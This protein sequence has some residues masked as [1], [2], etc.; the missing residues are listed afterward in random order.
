MMPVSTPKKIDDSIK[1]FCNS[2]Q[3][4]HSPTFVDFFEV[5][6]CKE[7]ECFYNVQEMVKHNGGEIIYG[8]TVWSWPNVYM[9]AEHHAVWRNPGGQL[10]DVTPKVH[11]EKI[12]LFLPDPLRSYDFATEKRL[13]NIR[14][15]LTQDPLVSQFLQLSG[16]VTA[17]IEK[18]STGRLASLGDDYMQLEIRRIQILDR[19]Y[20]KYL[21]PNDLCTCNSGKKIKKCCGLADAKTILRRS[22]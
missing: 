2:I 17:L 3:P 10:L 20:H 8:W 16:E 9:E 21:G 6:K 18:N 14:S 15:S 7:G 11:S 1:K 13:D 5:P 19:I 4:N 12:V 22:Q